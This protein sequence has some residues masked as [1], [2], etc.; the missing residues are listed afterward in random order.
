MKQNSPAMKIAS[1]KSW[2]KI[3]TTTP[4][5]LQVLDRISG[6]P[7]KEVVGRHSIDIQEPPIAGRPT[8][9]EIGNNETIVSRSKGR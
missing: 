6:S 5:V 9:R 4:K 3:M 1:N 7:M 2:P 8:A